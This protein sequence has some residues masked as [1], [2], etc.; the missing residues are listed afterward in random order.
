MLINQKLIPPPYSDALFPAFPKF[1][2]FSYK[3]KS[4]FREVVNLLDTMQHG[5]VIHLEVLEQAVLKPEHPAVDDGELVLGVGLLDGGGLDDVAA[6]LDDAELNEAVVAGRLVRDAVELLLVQAVDVPDVSKPRVEQ[7]KVLGRHGSLDAA[8][9]V[10]AAHDNVLDLQVAHGVL[11]YAHHVQVRVH[12][13]VRDVAMHEGLAWGQARDHL[14][15]DP[16]V[17]A[18]DPEVLG[19]LACRQLGEELGVLLPLLLRPRA[20]VLEQTVVRLLE[21]LGDIGLRHVVAP[22]VRARGGFGAGAGAGAGTCVPWK[23]VGLLGDG[24]VEG[25]SRR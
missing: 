19:R 1:F 5:L 17:A 7:A 8:A 14:R 11:D 20:V 9:A 18:P 4:T 21:V 6:L 12:H 3:V 16:R 15:R 24:W 23:V 22:T 25:S 10:V 13:Q 2:F